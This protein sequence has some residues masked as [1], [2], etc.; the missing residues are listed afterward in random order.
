MSKFA[1]SGVLVDAEP[2]APFIPADLEVLPPITHGL[3][4]ISG[5]ARIT[6]KGVG[7]TMEE[8]ALTALAASAV[9]VAKEL[10]Q[11]GLAAGAPI[12]AALP[13]SL[14]TIVLILAAWALRSPICLLPLRR[15]FTQTHT[16]QL[17]ASLSLVQPGALF[18]GD[19]LADAFDA[20]TTQA[21]IERR[22]SLG[23]LSKAAPGGRYPHPDPSDLAVL[24]LTSGSTGQPKAVPI[25][26]RHLAANVRGIARRAQVGR[27]DVIVS[28]M[29]IFH[30][31]GLSMV[32]LC[33]AS[34]SSLVLMCPQTFSSNPLSWLQALQNSRGSIAPATPSALRLLSR[35]K[36]RADRTGIDLHALRYMWVGAEPVFAADLERFQN[37][38]EPLGLG[39]QVLQPAYGL[40][41]AVVAVSVGSA[42]SDRALLSL[43]AA[44]LRLGRIKGLQDRTEQSVQLAGNGTPIHGIR[45]SI[46]HESGRKAS[47]CGVGEICVAGDS[48]PGHYLGELPRS[49]VGE[50]STG[51]LGFMRNGVLFVVGRSK[52]LI[53]RNGSNIAPQELERSV[54][55][56]WSLHP[57]TVI[58]FSCV[59]HEASRE[60]I[61]VLVDQR[62]QTQAGAS[63]LALIQH[64]SRTVGVLIDEVVFVPRERLP[65]TTSG[66]LQ[67]STARYLYVRAHGHHERSTHECT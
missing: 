14:D 52:E 34:G 10:R 33:V 49:G 28:W 57:G 63:A 26:H 58:A 47:D 43:S 41:E 8:A 1:K 15:P 30:D 38:Y 53:V 36:G 62:A 31:M 59:D 51:D 11:Q 17:S 39:Q 35:L 6:V 67:R 22:V 12:A 60:R 25:A 55:D 21:P 64:V 50:I 16:A 29:P 19:A 24:Q 42:G 61:V 37:D 65:R 2:S 46:R 45:V 44:E 48:I 27:H 7:G 20:V 18:I 66:K 13:T 32:T 5:E 3:E 40:A 4:D 56:L 23:M 9:T 54:E